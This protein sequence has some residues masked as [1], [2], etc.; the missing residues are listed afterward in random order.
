MTIYP[1]GKTNEVDFET[2][3]GHVNLPAI[4]SQLEESQSAA[5]NYYNRVSCAYD[6]WQSRWDGQTIDGR[7][8]YKGSA[9]DPSIFP[10]AGSSD[11]R[12]RLTK[13]IL[14]EWKTIT[15]YTVMNMKLQAQS[16]R[17]EVSGQTAGQE[18]TLIN[19]QIFTHMVSE[20]FTE[21]ELAL[22]WAGAVG[23][24]VIA[25]DWEQERRLDRVNL[26]RDQFGAWMS[27]ITRKQFTPNDIADMLDSAAYEGDLITIIQEMSDVL[28][29]G[30]ARK[31]LR[32]LQNPDKGV[33]IVPVPYFFRNK[34][35]IMALRPMIDVFFPPELDDF[36]RTPWADRLEY[37]TSEVLQD[38]IETQGY[39]KNFVELAQKQKGVYSTRYGWADW[40]YRGFDAYGLNIIGPHGVPAVAGAESNANKLIELHHFYHYGLDFGV[41]CLYRTVFHPNVAMEATHATSEYDHGQMP[42]HALRHET[43][44]R[45]I[46]SSQGIPELTYTWEN[47]SKVQ[48]DARTDRA[49]LALAP[50]MFT[51]HGDMAKVK[52]N[53]IPHGQIPTL[54]GREMKFAEVPPY[55]PGSI[56]ITMDIERRAREFFGWFGEIDPQLKQL[57]TMGLTDRTSMQFKPIVA[58]IGELDEQYL[59]DEV[60]QRVTGLPPRQGMRDRSSIQG[61]WEVTLT[62]DMRELDMEFLE[63]KAKAVASILPIDTA[64]I[65]D[66]TVIVRELFQG[67]SYTLADM[68]IRDPQSVSGK[69][70]EDEMAK[71]SLIIGSGVEQPLPPQGSNF[72]LRLQTLQNLI[73]STPGIKQRFAQD[74]NILKALE[75]RFLYLTRQIQQGKNAILG[76]TQ[77]GS[78]FDHLQ[79]PQIAEQVAQ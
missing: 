42:L 45:P 20:W 32:D 74:P 75:N 55:D 65:V 47:E 48:I 10:W 36:Q 77:V 66:R 52:A 25:V 68:S 35:R 9:S 11:A 79:P 16:T 7:R 15:M 34:P 14:N 23:C 46:L 56:E 57:K 2:T 59:P 43:D 33:A 76:K 18:T 58:Q 4:K 62:C 3:A 29:K 22:T 27:K 17:P 51:A 19:W 50:P 73:N 78:A 5:S 53:Y 26:S 54:P 61:R 13:R 44:H 1:G 63:K 70:I 28:S 40:I 31:I 6:W 30:D 67:F 69:E 38:R 41:P 21:C 64:G 72:G 71:A 37:V 60:W 12:V 24:S 49:S 8:W 39:D